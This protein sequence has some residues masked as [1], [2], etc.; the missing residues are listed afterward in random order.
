MGTASSEQEDFS[1]C[2]KCL[3]NLRTKDNPVFLLL[4]TV[5][6]S[7]KPRWINT[8]IWQASEEG[9]WLSMPPLVPQSKGEI[10]R[11]EI[12]IH[13][14]AILSKSDLQ[15]CCSWGCHLF[16]YTVQ[17]CPS[18]KTPVVLRSWLWIKVLVF[19]FLQL[20][21]HFPW[22]WPRAQVNNVGSS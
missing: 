11:G 8:E 18:F 12:F 20:P 3:P 19:N 16:K 9:S 5:P 2:Q 22:C 1:L 14:I 7:R 6:N 15:N 17:D 4:L 10:E 21:L 13:H